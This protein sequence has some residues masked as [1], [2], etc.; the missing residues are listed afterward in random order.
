MPKKLAS[1]LAPTF[2]DCCRLKYLNKIKGVF[3]A[4]ITPRRS[5][6]SVALLLNEEKH[7]QSFIDFFGYQNLKDQQSHFVNKYTERDAAMNES[8]YNAIGKTLKVRWFQA[9]YV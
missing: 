2:R 8:I 5:L 7:E 6:Q 1:T 3:S 4:L 9:H